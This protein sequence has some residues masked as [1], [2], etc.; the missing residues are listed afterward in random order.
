LLRIEAADHRAGCATTLREWIDPASGDSLA[1][2]V[3]SMPAIRVA[4]RSRPPDITKKI[5]TP[6]QT[7]RDVAPRDRE[8]PA[9]RGCLIAS[10]GEYLR[11]PL[12]TLA[13]E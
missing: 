12:R 1:R 8:E 2:G 5:S 6:R 9:G 13:A 11:Q 10:V 7:V 4:P 3:G